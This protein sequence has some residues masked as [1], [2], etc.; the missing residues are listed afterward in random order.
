[1]FTAQSV[2]FMPDGWKRGVQY[3]MS[4]PGTHTWAE[5]QATTHRPCTR[6]GSGITDLNTQ[7]H[8]VTV[9]WSHFG[10]THPATEKQYTHIIV[11]THTHKRITN[12]QLTHSGGWGCVYTEPCNLRWS[13]ILPFKRHV[14]SLMWQIENIHL[15]HSLTSA[16]LSTAGVPFSIA[17]KLQS[18][19]S[20]LV[21]ET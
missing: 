13:W 17:F 2:L 9:A 3:C 8:C 11:H 16:A 18:N 20:G 7:T 6:Q 5:K 4:P 21:S 14:D 12:L 10:E 1:M 15:W 19:L